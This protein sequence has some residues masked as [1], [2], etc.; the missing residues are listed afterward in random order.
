[1]SATRSQRPLLTPWIHLG[2]MYRLGFPLDDAQLAL[3]SNPTVLYVAQKSANP[4]IFDS[5]YA[6][7][8]VFKDNKFLVIV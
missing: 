6:I 7:N 8:A 3:T 5:K 4:F 2:V 1:M